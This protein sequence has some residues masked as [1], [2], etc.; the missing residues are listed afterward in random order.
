MYLLIYLLFKKSEAKSILEKKE[1]I[2]IPASE[3]NS[4]DSTSCCTNNNDN[5]SNLKSPESRDLNVVHAE[6]LNQGISIP[7]S[8]IKIKSILSKK[9]IDENSINAIPKSTNLI[10]ISKD[11]S[12]KNIIHDNIKK[13]TIENIEL[14]HLED[15]SEGKNVRRDSKQ[16]VSKPAFSTRN[17]LNLFNNNDIVRKIEGLKNHNK[18]VINNNVNYIDLSNSKNKL[19]IKI[20]TN[21]NKENILQDI[22]KKVLQ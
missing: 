19:K 17:V 15:K 13:V 10:K 6:H 12:T 8:N 9:K 16:N 11:D 3:T 1:K 5:S 21:G 4:S 22:G 7:H 2:E 18:L 20:S 14:A